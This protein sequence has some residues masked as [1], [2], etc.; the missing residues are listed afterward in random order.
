MPITIRD[1]YDLEDMS[2]D[3]IHGMLKYH[4]LEIEH[5]CKR[6]VGKSKSMA[7]KAERKLLKKLM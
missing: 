4:K 7:L 3:E 2:L 6:H 5:W 1:N